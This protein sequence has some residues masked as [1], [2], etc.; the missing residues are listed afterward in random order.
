[1][2]TH[3]CL[4]EALNDARRGRFRTKPSTPRRKILR[5]IRPS[6]PSR[7]ASCAV[8]IACDARCAMRD[9]RCAMRDARCAIARHA[10]AAHTRHSFDAG[11]IPDMV[12]VCG[13]PPE[14]EERRLPGHWGCDFIKGAVNQ[15]SVGALVERTSRFALLNEDE[16][17][18]RLFNACWLLR[19]TQFD[20]RV[21]ATKA[22]P[23]I[24]EKERRDIRRPLQPTWQ[25]YA[26]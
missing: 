26:I 10:H 17:C 20:R 8:I 1:M 4:V 18:H 21:L 12:S 2:A 11:R 9:A 7:K 5:G 24:R 25:V 19:K 13:R 3:A 23:A 14:I 22:S 16:T 15:S 6:T